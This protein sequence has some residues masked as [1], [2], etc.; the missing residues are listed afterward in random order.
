MFVFSHFSALIQ[1]A[2][3][4]ASTISPSGHFQAF[5]V[6]VTVLPPSLHVGALAGDAV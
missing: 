4:A 3:S 2:T 6:I 5:V 1:N